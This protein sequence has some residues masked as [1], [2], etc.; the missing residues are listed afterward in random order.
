MDEE[1]SFTAMILGSSYLL[2]FAAPVTF[3]TFLFPEK[4]FIYKQQLTMQK[5]HRNN[6]LWCMRYNH[7]FA[8]SQGFP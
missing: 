8:A 6:I 2:S 4:V 1:A 3:S 7:N 5:I